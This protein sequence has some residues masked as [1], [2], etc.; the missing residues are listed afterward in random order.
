MAQQHHGKTSLSVE[1]AKKIDGEIVSADSMQIYKE[2]DIGTAKVTKDEMQGVPHYLIDFVSPDSE[3]NVSMYK[4]D[5]INAINKIVEKNKIPIVVGGTG[6]YVDTLI[7]GIEFVEI[8]KDEEYRKYLEKEYEE[9]GIDYLFSMLQEVD[10][11]SSKKIDKQN[12]RRVIRALEIYKVTGKTKSQLDRESIK[13]TPY[14]YIVFGINWDR[15][16]LYDRIN[17]RVDIMLN[18]GLL[19]E[20][21]NLTSKYNLS[22]TALQGLGY[23]EVISYFNNEIT[24]DEMVNKI[25]QESRRYA[26]RQITWFKHIKNI[27]WLNGENQDEMIERIV[28][29]VHQND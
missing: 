7:N 27:I 28:K 26:K 8:E 3:Y 2:M 24:Y 5:A 11:E 21:K 29:E 20:V 18:N 16:K 4:D 25:K 12:V 22:K 10:E 14:D 6:L 13:E 23:K 17:R 15:E 9:K 19:D 1:L